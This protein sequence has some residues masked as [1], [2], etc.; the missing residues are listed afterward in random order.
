MQFSTAFAF[1]KNF[2]C[3]NIAYK[4][5]RTLG[6]TEHFFIFNSQGPS[7]L[8]V[9]PCKE[10]RILDSEKFFSCG[11][12]NPELCTVLNPSSTDKESAVH[13]LESGI[14][15]VESRIQDLLDHIT[16]G[17]PRLLFS[18]QFDFFQFDFLIR[19]PYFSNLIS[20][21]GIYILEVSGNI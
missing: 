5:G 18:F 6:V 21:R 10:I 11:I 12:R 2:L 4:I 15:S 8:E 19:I 7:F 1:N 14:H 9:A 16:W 13:Y 20:K 3:P 17:D